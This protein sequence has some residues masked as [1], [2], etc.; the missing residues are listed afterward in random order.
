MLT[1]PSNN[2][3]KFIRVT[4]FKATKHAKFTFLQKVEEYT[5]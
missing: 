1:I 3:K 5:Q 4:A 2:H